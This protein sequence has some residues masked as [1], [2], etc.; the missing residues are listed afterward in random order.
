[1]KKALSVILAALMA[2]MS[3]PAFAFEAETVEGAYELPETAAEEG[4]TADY[5]GQEKRTVG[6]G[7]SVQ[8]GIPRREGQV[9]GVDA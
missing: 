1:M 4:Q 6:G 8:R 3:I 5:D 2:A 9:R 7:A